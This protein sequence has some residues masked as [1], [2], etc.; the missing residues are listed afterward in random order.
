LPAAVT[1]A[2]HMSKISHTE[3][4]QHSNITH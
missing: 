1:R 3:P 4:H 2:H